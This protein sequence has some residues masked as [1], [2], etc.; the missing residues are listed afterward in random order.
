M[1]D[2][3]IEIAADTQY[4]ATQ[5]VPTFNIGGTAPFTLECIV[6]IAGLPTN[7]GWILTFADRSNQSPVNWDKSIRIGQT[8]K[9]DG[10]VWSGSEVLAISTTNINDG[11]AHHLALTYDGTTL[12]LYVDGQAEGSNTAS[13]TYNY[14]GSAAIL[15]NMSSFLGKIDEVRVWSVCRSAQD[16]N[17]YKNKELTGSEA[18]LIGYWKFAEGSGTVAA[19]STANAND[20]TLVNGVSWTDSL[21]GG[22]TIYVPV[23]Q[24]QADLN[25]PLYTP[26]Q[27]H[28]PVLETSVQMKPVIT[29][30]FMLRVG[31]IDGQLELRAPA[32]RLEAIVPSPVS[33]QHDLQTPTWEQGIFVPTIEILTSLR[34]PA[35][36]IVIPESI[37][38]TPFYMLV[39][40]GAADGQTDT[41]LPME[42][43]E[44]RA[45]SGEPTYLRATI[46]WTT[47]LAQAVTARPNGELVVYRG[48]RSHDGLEVTDEILRVDLEDIRIDKGGRK[49]SITLVGHKQ[50][51][52]QNPVGIELAGAIYRR[53]INGLRTY[54]VAASNWL[55]PGD[56]VTLTDVGE[57]LTVGVVSW[58]VGRNQE[59]VEIQEAA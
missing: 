1:A 30:P 32:A 43:F 27:S 29:D 46:P 17:A 8:G 22:P 38:Q 36:R 47:E 50:T 18:G 58:I 26:V 40:T 39:L 41:V 35:G 59:I 42:S 49:A 4:A 37:P 53:E 55:R 5:V 9:V 20:M 24:V 2:Y 19:D 45:R 14:G 56:T 23:L 51:T 57:T 54:R 31:A 44:A 10:Y 34:P 15:I 12:T 33:I 3:A 7:I 52:N 11:Q 28:P 13:S 6:E 25:T 16:I 48:L 21:L